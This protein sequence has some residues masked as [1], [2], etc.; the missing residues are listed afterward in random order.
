MHQHPVWPYA[1]ISAPPRRRH[2]SPLKTRSKP[3][4][5][6]SAMGSRAMETDAMLAAKDGV[7]ILMHDEVLRAHDPDRQGSS[8]N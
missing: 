5:R 3:S 1:R 8:L 2:R 7:P 6:A 4:A